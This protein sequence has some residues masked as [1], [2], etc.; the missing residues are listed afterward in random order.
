MAFARRDPELPSQYLCRICNSRIAWGVIVRVL[1][2]DPGQPAHEM[3]ENYLHLDCARQAFVPRVPLAFARHWG[4]AM[5]LPDDSAELA[6]Q[7]CGLCDKPI[8]AGQLT[9]LRLQRPMGRVRAPEFDEES[10]AVHRGCLDSIAGPR[11]PL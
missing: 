8:P 11:P 6:G 5:P 4:G 3:R 10:V 1:R 7:A 9:R 2:T